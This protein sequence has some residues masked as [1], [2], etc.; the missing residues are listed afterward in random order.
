MDTEKKRN[1]TSSWSGY[2][3]QGQVGFL[4]ALRTIKECIKHNT[5]NYGDYKIAYENTED[6]DIIDDQDRV[7]SRH[8][9][10]AYTNEGFEREKYENVLKVQ[11]RK[12]T[13][14]PGFQVGTFDSNGNQISIDVD[15]NHRYLHTV[16]EVP[17][18]YFSETKY[19]AK[20]PKRKKYTENESKVKLYSYQK[21]EDFC[22]LPTKTKDY[23]EEYSLTE[24]KTILHNKNSFLENDT[25]HH[26][27]VYVRYMVNLLGRRIGVAHVEDS[28]PSINF[29]EIIELID[30]KIVEDKYVE[31]KYN[32]AHYWDIYSLENQ[33]RLSYGCLETMNIIINDFL[34]KSNTEYESLLRRLCPHKDKDSDL[35]D[36]FSASEIEN[37]FFYLIESLQTFN[38]ETLTYVDKQNLDY[39]VSLISTP[40]P[41]VLNMIISR[42]LSNKKLLIDSFTQ[43]YLINQQFNGVKLNK[44]LLDTNE[45]S[46]SNYN[47]SINPS[48]NDSIFNQNME[49]IGINEALEKLEDN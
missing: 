25:N 10:K 11:K 28:F 49:F 12:P 33:E 17:E 19:L 31:S 46:Y 42:I 2:F 13:D 22:K 1:A 14:Q 4:V 24:I 20:H 27:N 44:Q 48:K 5:S 15:E 36:L 26:M 18:F 47:T 37:I 38:F 30:N 8:Q 45:E 6:F 34:N 23:L 43:N 39:R 9:V 29:S 7:V 21:G 40:H 32:L 41:A 3:H 16:V 35:L